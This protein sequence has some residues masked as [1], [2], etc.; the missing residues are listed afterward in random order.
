M[1]EQLPLGLLKRAL[2]WLWG[3]SEDLGREGGVSFRISEG[4]G[5]SD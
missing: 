4:V 2:G 5:S 1:I 3:I